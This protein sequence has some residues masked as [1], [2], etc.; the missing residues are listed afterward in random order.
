MTSA[1]P[2]NTIPLNTP[3]VAAQIPQYYMKDTIVAWATIYMDCT[4]PN[5]D[6]VFCGEVDYEWR[7]SKLIDLCHLN[8]K[9]IL[10]SNKDCGC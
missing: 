6:V 5:Q 4:L 7:L 1:H 9:I 8:T 10:T 2:D 3:A